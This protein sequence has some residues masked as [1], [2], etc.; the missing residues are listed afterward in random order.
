MLCALTRCHIL[1]RQFYEDRI[2]FLKGCRS[3]T[4]YIQR[5]GCN[6]DAFLLFMR[7]ICSSN[8][9][10]PINNSL[11]I[12][13]FIEFSK[14]LS[15]CLFFRDVISLVLCIS[16]FVSLNSDLLQRSVWRSVTNTGSILPTAQIPD[17]WHVR[18][19]GGPGHNGLDLHGSGSVSL[20]YTLQCCS[21]QEEMDVLRCRLE[22][23]G[24]H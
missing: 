4:L 13:G 14:V 8:C 19:L 24:L 7:T 23:T 12:L 16:A 9:N 1:N 15:N 11:N 21:G 10:I 22:H 18:R 6:I 5:C 2:K 20:H 17:L 3:M